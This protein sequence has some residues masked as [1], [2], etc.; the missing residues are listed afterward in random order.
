[1]KNHIAVKVF[2]LTLTALVCAPIA[3][4]QNI[5]PSAEYKQLA[6]RLTS[7]VQHELKG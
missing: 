7:L 2:R 6:D 4:A 5:A 1:M 3:A